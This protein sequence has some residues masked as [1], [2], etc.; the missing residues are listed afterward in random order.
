MKEAVGF[1][2]CLKKNSKIKYLVQKYIVDVK[3]KKKKNM[4]D[5]LILK[6][7]GCCE[8][9]TMCKMIEFKL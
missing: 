3:K 2:Q 8:F 5:Q 4:V 9:P 6:K 1:K 7:K